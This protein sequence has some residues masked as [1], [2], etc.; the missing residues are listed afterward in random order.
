MIYIV[1]GPAKLTEKP[2]WAML[3]KVGNQPVVTQ[4]NNRGAPQQQQQTT[5]RP[6]T[7][8]QELGENQPNGAPPGE[9]PPNQPPQQQ[10]GEGRFHQGGQR[11]FR[12]HLSSPGPC[13]YPDNQQLFIGRIPHNVNEQQLREAFSRKKVVLPYCQ[14]L[15]SATCQIFVSRVRHYRRFAHSETAGRFNGQFRLCRI[16]ECGGGGKMP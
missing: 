10:R 8:G 4:P 13:D 11:E 5:P 2:S 1:V 16:R 12:T 14:W 6:P 3:V 7:S 9:V 15:L